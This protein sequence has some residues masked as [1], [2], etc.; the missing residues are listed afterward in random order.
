MGS[1]NEKLDYLNDTKQLIR[2][3]LVQRGQTV[4]D[5]TP[6]RDYASKILN[7]DTQSDFIDNRT[8]INDFTYQNDGY[9]KDMPNLDDYKV[10]T[11]V[12]CI[13]NLY[14]AESVL[15]QT[16]FVIYQIMSVS[17]GNAHCKVVDILDEYNVGDIKLFETEEEMN[18]DNSAKEGDLAVVYREEIQNMTV[19]TQTQYIT[20]P[21]TVVLPEA[22]TGL[23]FIMLRA[24]DESVMFEGQAMLDKNSFRFDGWSDTGMVRVSYTSS[25]GINYTR[26]EFMGDS[27]DLS[28]PVDL[29]T[30]IHC[31][32]SEEWN[33]NMGYF[34]Q[35]G[36]MNF[37]G[38]FE[39]GEYVDKNYLHFWSLDGV[40]F[41]IEDGNI[42]N[43][44]F[45]KTFIEK[46]IDIQKLST[47]LTKF[48]KE[49][50]PYSYSFVNIY[51]DSSD[52]ICLIMNSSINQTVSTYVYN[53]SKEFL[54]L[55]TPNQDYSGSVNIYHLNLENQT[56]SLVSTI[57]PSGECYYS[58]G[59]RHYYDVDIKSFGIECYVS[60]STSRPQ[61]NLCSIWVSS[62]SAFIDNIAFNE[63]TC[64]DKYN[65]YQIAPSQLTL[66]SSNQLLPEVKAYGKNGNITGDDSLYDN[67]DAKKIANKIYQISDSTLNGLEENVLLA[68]RFE[69][70]GVVH[71]KLYGFSL[72]GKESI[73]PTIVYEKTK[74]PYSIKLPSLTG[75]SIPGSSHSVIYGEYVYWIVFLSLENRCIIL[76]FKIDNGVLDF[77]GQTSYSVECLYDTTAGYTVIDDIVYMVGCN[78]G[79]NSRVVLYGYTFNL[80]TEE[81]NTFIS[82][83]TIERNTYYGINITRLDVENTTIGLSYYPST[84]DR[85]ADT[86][87]I[88][89][90]W[91][92]KQKVNSS[93][94]VRTCAPHVYDSYNYNNEFVIGNAKG[95]FKKA[96]LYRRSTSE[97]IQ[98]ITEYTDET[99][100]CIQLYVDNF[101]YFITEKYK[102][103]KF[104]LDDLSYEVFDTTGRSC[105]YR[106]TQVNGVINTE[107]YILFCISD[108]TASSGYNDCLCVI[109]KRKNDFYRVSDI[110]SFVQNVLYQDN[111]INYLLVNSWGNYVFNNESH[112]YKIQC[113]YLTNNII[114]ADLVLFPLIDIGGIWSTSTTYMYA[115][116]Q[117][118]ARLFNV[119]GKLTDTE[120]NQALET[121][122]EIEGAEDIGGVE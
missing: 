60:E 16:A 55:T 29:G 85:A 21:E 87:Y 10:N 37:G 46:K 100:D 59:V 19:D 104:N 91:T 15:E 8:V 115:N 105:D 45:D 52:N 88:D 5:S 116:K 73:A 121:A 3:S 119:E 94:Y 58:D 25:D 24:V 95:D 4:D 30:T 33:D 12:L 111:G 77:I 122:K 81:F 110:P 23:S 7:I 117:N 113:G 66:T 99:Y 40:S 71:N 2:S 78:S 18:S 89:Y 27:G 103:L 107:D 102:M 106:I 17:D 35:I 48:R 41:D 86:K 14:S 51:L 44:V 120:Y 11:T 54:G 70:I 82:G 61:I 72:D 65:E 79:G 28:N 84:S 50:T 64:Y 36:G 68:N 49:V 42:I 31:E 108:D 93:L 92:T 62:T 69:D 97:I 38:L 83:D 74:H 34:M 90:N 109:D 22:F 43:E 53:E 1:I 63:D 39:Y 20:F 96:Y 47:L 57:N 75:S 80:K 112:N 13:G 76:K 118:V 26:E 98:D 9:Y 114:D 101:L 32:M 67:L 6:F 56:Y